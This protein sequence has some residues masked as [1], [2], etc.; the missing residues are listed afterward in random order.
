MRAVNFDVPMVRTIFDKKATHP[1][2]CQYQP[3][4]GW[5]SVEAIL[6]SLLTKVG[7]FANRK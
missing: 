5:I 4:T 3:S 7:V 1:L 2:G 6:Q